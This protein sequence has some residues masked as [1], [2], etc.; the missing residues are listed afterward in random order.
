MTKCIITQ[1]ME[2]FEGQ[3]IKLMDHPTYSPDLSPF[4]LCRFP[5]IKEEF[6][7]KT[8]QDINE[9]DAAIEEQIDQGLRKEDFSQCFEH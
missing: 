6:R 9:L 2:Y 1:T 4:D 5:K 3:R 8:F 7:R